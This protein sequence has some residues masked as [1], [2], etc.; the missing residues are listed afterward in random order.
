MINIIKKQIKAW[1]MVKQNKDIL[2]PCVKIC[3]YDNNF[4][5]G[6]VCIGCFREQYEISNWLKMTPSEQQQVLIGSKE[7]KAQFKTY[8]K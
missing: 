3:K 1:F 4:M 6:M 7:R 2:S 8:D 5:N